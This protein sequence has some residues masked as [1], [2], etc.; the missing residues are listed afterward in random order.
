MQIAILSRETLRTL[1]RWP[2]AQSSDCRQAYDGAT[3]ILTPHKRA[4]TRG[5]W[6]S[7]GA[8]AG[9]PGNRRDIARV[10]SGR[11]LLLG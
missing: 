7:I 5:S 10:G 11:D 4:C 6:P 1:Q 2:S 8:C 9:L 3:E